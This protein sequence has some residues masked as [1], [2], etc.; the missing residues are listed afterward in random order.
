M[1]TTMV[2]ISVTAE[3]FLVESFMTGSGCSKLVLAAAA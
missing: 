3:K 2:G 1:I